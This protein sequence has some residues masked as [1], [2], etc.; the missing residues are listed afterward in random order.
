MP[1]GKYWPGKVK[2]AEQ[3]QEIPSSTAIPTFTP[4]TS[5]NPVAVSAK[6][7]EVASDTVDYILQVGAMSH[8]ENADALAE[9]L[10]QKDFPVFIIQP[11]GGR[12]YRVVVGPYDSAAVAQNTRE[13]LT[14]Q[15]FGSV[16]MQRTNPIKQNS[17]DK[18]S[19]LGTS[20]RS[21]AGSSRSWDSRP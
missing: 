18:L 10:R 19:L 9:S 11:N 2:R 5:L 3:P 13:Q 6:E 7:P 8:E 21:Q 1:I 15:G 12:F 16:L 4:S 17:T 20:A 14:K